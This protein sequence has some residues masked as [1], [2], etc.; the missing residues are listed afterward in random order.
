MEG[1]HQLKYKYCNGTDLPIR[2]SYC[3]HT[4]QLFIWPGNLEK[5]YGN[6]C[7]IKVSGSY[8]TVLQ[9]ITLCLNNL[10]VPAQMGNR[11]QTCLDHILFGKTWSSILRT[12]DRATVEDSVTNVPQCTST[13]HSTGPPPVLVP[14]MYLFFVTYW[15]VWTTK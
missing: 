6:A 14:R 8:S 7:L 12:L 10:R 11:V 3:I 9:W 1:L 4:S 15:S 2:P 5:K 13:S